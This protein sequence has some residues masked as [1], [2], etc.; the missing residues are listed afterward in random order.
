MGTKKWDEHRTYVETDD[1]IS[2]GWVTKTVEN[3]WRAVSTSRGRPEIVALTD[4]K[5][6]AIEQV[7]GH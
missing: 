4:T 5:K 7:K 3:K 1:G 2:V 6:E